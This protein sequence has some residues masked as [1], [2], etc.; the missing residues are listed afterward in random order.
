MGGWGDDKHFWLVNL[1]TQKVT[2][3]HACPGGGYF[4][5]SPQHRLKQHFVYHFVLVLFKYHLADK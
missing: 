2:F 1:P 3:L 4:Q 5:P